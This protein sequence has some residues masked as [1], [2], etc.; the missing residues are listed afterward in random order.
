MLKFETLNPQFPLCRITEEI[1]V[2]LMK[3]LLRELLFQKR[4][5]PLLVVIF[6][7]LSK[8]HLN[9]F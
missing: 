3:T 2:K 5:D 4:E 9:W 7:L 1:Y 8:R 6:T